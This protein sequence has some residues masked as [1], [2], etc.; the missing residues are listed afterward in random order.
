[1]KEFTAKE[2]HEALVRME[3]KWQA[4]AKRQAKIQ[5]FIYNLL[6]GVAL[7]ILVCLPILM[8]MKGV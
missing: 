1:M 6:C 3:Q 2:I 4:R 8:M 5:A 7:F